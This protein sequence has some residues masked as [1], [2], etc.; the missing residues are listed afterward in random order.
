MNGVSRGGITE[1]VNLGQDLKKGGNSYADNGGGSVP[2]RTDDSK[3]KDPLIAVARVERVRKS[4]RRC[5]QRH[6]GDPIPLL[7]ATIRT[8]VLFHVR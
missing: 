4:R 6:E 7:R 3:D 1:K 2:G 5:G 8:W